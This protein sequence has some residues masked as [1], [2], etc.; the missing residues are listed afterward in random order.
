MYVTL[1]L[2]CILIIIEVFIN[3]KY[4]NRDTIKKTYCYLD[5]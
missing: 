1:S 2:V 4:K 3:I 5:N